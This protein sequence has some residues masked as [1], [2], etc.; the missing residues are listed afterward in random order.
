MN[1]EL[2]KIDAIA[3]KILDIYRNRLS[4]YKLGDSKLAK[5]LELVPTVIYDTRLV[6][7]IRLQ[8]YWFFVEDGRRKGAIPPPVGVIERWMIDKKIPNPTKSHA[9]AI[10]KN[11]GKNGIP[12]KPAWKGTKESPEFDAVIDEIRKEIRRQIIEQVIN[13]TN[14]TIFK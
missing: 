4:D 2:E 1:L 7:S 11:I 8:N 3:E 10:A 9:F 13:E 5:T 12:A 14:E 6:I